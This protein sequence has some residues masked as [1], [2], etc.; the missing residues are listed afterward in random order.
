MPRLFIALLLVSSLSAEVDFSRDVQPI[1]NKNCIAC[2]GGVKEASEVSFIYRDQVLG[3]GESGK[4][5]VIPGDPDG[6]EMMVRI[7]SD[8]P[9]LL[10]P[11]P[12]HGPRLSDE[13]VKT[14]RNWI[15]EGAKWGEHWSFT[16]PK[17]HKA[18][19]VKD[20]TWPVGK[21]DHFI[22]A[23]LESNGL[24]P[25][26]PARPAEWLRRAS[27][28][29]IGL[30]PTIAELDA[31]EVAAKND[32]AQAIEKETDRLLASPHF[33]ERWA[34][35]WMDL[36][37]YAD[38]EGL[39]NDRKRDVWK[40]REWL[41]NAFN[42]NLPYD[43]FVIEQLAGDA[44]PNATLEQK[45]ATTFH[46]LTQANSEGGTDDEEFRLIAAMDR[47]V[48]TWEV[49]QGI[50][51]NCVQCHSHPY[52]P[53]KHE[54]YYNS[55]KFFNNTR[56]SDAT[57]NSPVLPI[58]LDPNK[59]AEAN[60]LLNK[61][62]QLEQ[63][64]HDAWLEVDKSSVWHPVTQLSAS[65]NT[66]HLSIVEKD[67]FAEFRASD[68][69]KINSIYTLTA[70]VPEKLKEFTAFRLTYLPKDEG[71]AL[72]DA[73]WG[74]SLNHI[75]V[76]KIGVDG[77]AQ[78][79]KLIDVIPD[80]AHP[81]FNPNKSLQKRGMGWGTYY[82]F[83]R[84]R[85]ATFVLSEVLPVGEGEKIRFTL[86]N[87]GMYMASF[88]LVAKRGRIS[89][90]DDSAWVTGQTDSKFVNAR[91]DLQQ[92]RK[93]LNT[94]PHVNTLVIA[95]RDPEHSRVTNFFNRGNWLDKGQVIQTAS[96]PS[97]FPPMQAKAGKP[98]RLD[99]ARWIASPKNPLT[100]RVFVNRLWLEVF[101]VGIVP[102]PEDFGSAGEK[103]THPELLDT[104]AV[105]FATEMK[106]DIKAMLRR[107]LTSAAYRQSNKVS[108][109]LHELDA[110]N[111]LLTRG[112]RQRLTGEMARDSALLASGLLS[113]KIHGPPTFPPLP[114]GVWRP[115]AGPKW[116]TPEPGD[117]ER[118]RRAVYT[119]WKRSI[120]YPTFI[121]FDAPTR[122]MCSKRRM[123]SNTPIQAL[124][125]MNDPAFH[126]CAQVLGQRML[127]CKE[128]SVHAKIALGYRATTSQR[129]TPERLTELRKLFDKLE[130]NFTDNPLQSKKL[131]ET[132]DGAAYAVIAS[133]LLNLDEAITR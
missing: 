80:E 97:V 81:F 14:L 1:L 69:A 94:I 87:G 106:W 71:K 38:S 62:D 112:P 65:S 99:F 22:L 23:K 58:P 59:Y 88:A 33:G 73:E 118:Y 129:I 41:I 113:R 91:S 17:K 64:I 78:L 2:H 90:S 52:D 103:P 67:G 13:D 119:F 68:N 25:S 86:Q 109:K 12:E 98:N 124:A 77:K 7:T 117:P 74:A 11:Q 63:T 133:V 46:R 50:S 20:S 27:L 79:V 60:N 39:G 122:E 120:P 5:V 26:A 101:G 53:L 84:P 35:V 75:Q 43:Q 116:K 82:K 93:Q 130:Q 128:E 45:I 6:S 10:M 4:I 32:Y 85:H 70:Q 89:L 66:A 76:E 92:A 54:E 8:D 108:P 114:P 111:R 37:R 56:D 21:I 100:A 104:L 42:Q 49:F 9:E 31:F 115:F 105:E 95:E 28:D 29:I 131:A 40:F 102:T 110:S 126:E 34:S 19:N 96:T 123:P 18:P 121:T 16:S 125:V 107:Y 15:K 57:D 55:L 132:A 44:I 30:P 36:A 48:T 3:K 72:T 127:M 24:K 47:N 51:M 83:F 61:I